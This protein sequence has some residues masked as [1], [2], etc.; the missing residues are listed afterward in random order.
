M[1]GFRRV[2]ATELGMAMADRGH[3]VHFDSEVTAPAAGRYVVRASAE[4]AENVN[5]RS[6]VL[7]VRRQTAEE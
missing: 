5:V 3:R 1:T 6:A 2:I 4:W 7:E